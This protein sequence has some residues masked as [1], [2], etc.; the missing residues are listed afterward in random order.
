MKKQKRFD[1]KEVK[2]LS[3]V[4][5][6]EM[7][8][9]KLSKKNDPR[10]QSVNVVS[11]MNYNVKIRNKTLKLR[12]YKSDLPINEEGKNRFE[13][14][15]KTKKKTTEFFKERV[16]E[17]QYI[18]KSAYL[19]TKMVIEELHKAN[20]DKYKMNKTRYNL[21]KCV[22]DICEVYDY[23]TH[24]TIPKYIELELKDN[25][26][27]L[28]DMKIILHDLMP[29]LDTENLI[30][31]TCGIRGIIDAQIKVGCSI[32]DTDNKPKKNKKNK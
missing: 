5:K 31:S 26:L 1:E 12:D 14:I 20:H 19:T 17:Q 7:G 9:D 16:E 32:G 2:I 15:I 6:I 18:S 10:I 30:V 11:H 25:S 23:T 29:K 27:T 8:L 28:N 21:E 3:H 13:V 24:I 22:I 4:D